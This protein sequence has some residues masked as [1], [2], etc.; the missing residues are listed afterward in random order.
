MNLVSIFTKN[1]EKFE[2]FCPSHFIKHKII[3]GVL[4]GITNM[5]AT[6][7][8]FMVPSLVGALTEGKVCNF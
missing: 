3:L 7:P 4:M 8:G 6:I 1:M 5:F 2:A